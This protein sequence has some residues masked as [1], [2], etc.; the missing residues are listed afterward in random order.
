MGKPLEERAAKVDVAAAK[1]AAAEK[2]AAEKK[3]GDV[4]PEDD[5]EM[6]FFEHV[7]ELRTRLVRALWGFI[8]GIGIAWYFKEQIFEFLTQPLVASWNTAGF[9]DPQIHISNPVDAFVGYLLIAVVCG[10]IIGSPWAFYQLWQFIAPGLYRRERRLAIPFVLFSAIC[11]VGGAFFGYALVLPPAFDTLLS[12]AGMLPSG[13]LRI[14]PTI[15][16]MDYLE[17][18]L[19]ML[20]ALG[21]TFEVPV[22]IS[23]LALAGI[24]NY[25]Q[26]ISFSRWWIVLSSVAAAILTPSTDAGSMFLVMIPLVGLYFVSIVLAYFLGPKPGDPPPPPRDD[27]EE[28]GSSA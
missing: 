7:G 16:L 22:V 10:G 8:P 25:R 28:E 19:R 15:M 3:K 6:T 11:F 26:L 1:A 12:F 4:D 20:L 21:I 27:D 18:S 2:E 5:V 14:Q 9:G 24:V 13:E 17:F 23:F